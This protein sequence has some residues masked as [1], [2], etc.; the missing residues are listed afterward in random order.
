MDELGEPGP[1][2]ADAVERLFAG[3]QVTDSP[4]LSSAAI[5]DRAKVVACSKIRPSGTLCLYTGIRK[6]DARVMRS[7]NKGVL[8]A[9]ASLGR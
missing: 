4:R 5:V 9:A 8:Y 6:I 1:S 7:A 2:V 3:S